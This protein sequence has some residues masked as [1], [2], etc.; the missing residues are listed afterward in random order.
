[1]GILIDADDFVGKWAIAQDDYSTDRIDEYITTFEKKY[2]VELLGVELFDLFQADLVAQVPQTAIYISIFNEFYIDDGSCVFHS[3]GMKKML[4]GM[5]YF[6]YVRDNDIK[7]TPSGTFKNTSELANAF[8][9][10][11]QVVQRWNQ[12]T[13][14]FGVIQWYICDNPTDYPTYNGQLI[15]HTS[16]I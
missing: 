2:L 11:N 12:S 15:Q 13:D 9:S 3:E 14:T 6:Q 16:G 1:M 8:P 4:L 10:F 7:Q 5:I